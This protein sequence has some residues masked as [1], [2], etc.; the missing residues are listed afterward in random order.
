[1]KLYRCFIFDKKKASSFFSFFL[2]GNEEAKEEIR[3]VLLGKTGSGK[4]STANT[5]LGEY[6]FE[7]DCS[8]TSVTS[9]CTKRERS[10]FEKDILIVD[11]PGIFDTTQ[12][13]EE[14]K[15][16]IKKCVGITAPGPHAF[17]LV[18]SVTRYTKEELDTIDNF[19]TWFGEKSYEY[20]II[21]FTSKERLDSKGRELKDHI[22]TC[23][24]KLKSY[25]EKC[26]NR[27]IAFNNLLPGESKD[28]QVKDLLSMISKNIARNEGKFYTNEMYNDIEAKLKKMEEEKIKKAEKER[29]V[30]EDEIRK[31]IKSEIAENLKREA[32]EKERKENLEKIRAKEQRELELL[33]E[34]RDEDRREARSF[35]RDAIEGVSF[36]KLA[37]QAIATGVGMVYDYFFG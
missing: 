14:I 25:V 21:L 19:F 28:R 7:S 15:H 18:L 5:I 3:I 22:E 16:E 27:V 13:N 6:L 34:E 8:G 17:I 2:S 30:R 32:S 1:M 20:F 29:K 35:I 24:D 26:G 23:P 33:N 4:S 11:T 36:R 31:R 10:R 12:T 37:T 9:K